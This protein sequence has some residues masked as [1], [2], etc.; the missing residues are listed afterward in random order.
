MM[1]KV[2]IQEEHLILLIHWARRYCDCRMTGVAHKFNDIYQHIR[3][4]HPDT[5]GS[6]DKF[7]SALMEEGSYWPY[8]Q[9]GMYKQGCRSF[10]ALENI[11]NQI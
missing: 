4:E 3:S 2:E 1:K 10:N 8:A 9:D 7:D 6:K 5:M 11:K